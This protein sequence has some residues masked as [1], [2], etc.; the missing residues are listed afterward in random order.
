MTPLPLVTPAEHPYCLAAHD[1]VQ[2][3]EGLLP[4]IA[5]LLHRPAGIWGSGGRHPQEP[6]DGHG[7]GDRHEDD[8]D[9]E[10]REEADRKADRICRKEIRLCRKEREHGATADRRD[11]GGEISEHHFSAISV[12]VVEEPADDRTKAA[13]ADELKRRC[14]GL[15]PEHL[16][17][18]R[19]GSAALTL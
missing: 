3:I 9:G 18:K 1:V 5:L 13:G 11:H 2:P 14:R 16:L 8:Q 7:L 15:Q 10:I 17:G 4:Q 6:I 12:D 19:T